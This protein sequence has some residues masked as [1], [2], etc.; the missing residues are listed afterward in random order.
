MPKSRVSPLLV[1]VEVAGELAPAACRVERHQITGTV[2]DHVSNRSGS[3]VGIVD[4]DGQFGIGT[5]SLK[6]GSPR[7]GQDPE[8][9]VFPEKPGG[10]HARAV[11]SHPR[12]Q[13][14]G[15]HP[16]DV[17]VGRGHGGHEAAPHVRVRCFRSV[18]GTAG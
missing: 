18:S 14:L 16:V 1:L 6:Q 12:G 11:G 8:C 4:H 13:R 10:A 17:E 5:H 7:S 3:H 15:E 2:G 9:A